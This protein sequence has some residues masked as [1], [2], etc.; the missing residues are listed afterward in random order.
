M[1]QISEAVEKKKPGGARLKKG[2]SKKPLFIAGGIAL[3]QQILAVRNHARRQNFPLAR[4]ELPHQLLPE[5][6]LFFAP[7]AAA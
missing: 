2:S 3:Q 1:E 6:A 5:T 7:V 4:T